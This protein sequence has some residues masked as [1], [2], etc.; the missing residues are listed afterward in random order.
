MRMSDIILKK[1]D[2]GEL[3]TAEIAYIVSA[4]TAEILPDYQMSALLMAIFFRGMSARETSDLTLALAQSGSVMDLSQIIGI[5][6]DK[7]STGGVADTTTLVLAP[8]AASAGVPVAKM[9]GRGLGHTGGTIDKLE[10]IP[11]FRVDLRPEEFI[12]NV[13]TVGLAIMGQTTQL[14][15]ADGKLYA[16]RDVTGTVESIPLIASS[17]MSKKI[18]AGAEAIVLDVK[19][20][21]GAFMKDPVRAEE[22]AKTMV[23]IGNG[24]GRKTVALVTN[25]DEPL[26]RAVGNALEVREAIDTLRGEGPPRLKELC[27]LLGSHMVVMAGIVNTIEEAL[28]LLTR[29]LENGEALAALRRMI[30]A[31]H[32]DERII[33]QPDLLPQAAHIIPVV[34]PGEGYVQSI[35]AARIGLYAMLLGAGRS[36]KEDNIDLAVGIISEKRVG[37]Y[38]NVQEPLAIIH[39]N[40]LDDI[41]AISS[42]VRSC[43]RLG[44]EI[45]P[46]KPLVHSTIV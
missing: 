43:Y 32:G 37:D 41:E 20:G 30:K 38:V 25:M 6:V 7:H 29:K 24:T 4:Y 39:A 16:L 22:L 17:V 27:L 8:L 15:P 9:S 42:A 33:D 12:H 2:G 19:Y 10:A 34:A 13:N 21:S 14:A 35:D 3:T 31:Q 1:R 44:W 28:P 40:R 26:G 18:A 23:A 5:K 36:T 46:P 11:G 45:V